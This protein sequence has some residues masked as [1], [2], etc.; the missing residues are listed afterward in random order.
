ME[1]EAEAAVAVAVAVALASLLGWGVEEEYNLWF[2]TASILTVDKLS[3]ALMPVVAALFASISSVLLLKTAL[4]DNIFPVA[5]ISCLYPSREKEVGDRY[6]SRGKEKLL[7]R[8]GKQHIPTNEIEIKTGWD[9]AVDLLFKVTT[10]NN[11]KRK[12]LNTRI[13]NMP[14]LTVVS[15]LEKLCCAAIFIR[16]VKDNSMLIALLSLSLQSMCYFVRHMV[17]T[18]VGARTMSDE[19]SISRRKAVIDMLLKSLAYIQVI[20]WIQL[21]SVLIYH[22]KIDFE[23]DVCRWS[24][25][26]VFTDVLGEFECG[27]GGKP[28]L[29]LLDL[30]ILLGQLQM[31]TEC[32]T[33]CPTKPRGASVLPSVRDTAVNIP[34]W[35]LHKYGILS[36][37][38]FDS[39]GTNDDELEL[40]AGNGHGSNGISDSILPG[41]YG[42]TV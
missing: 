37:L 39:L 15:Q 21:F 5:V 42:S 4:L 2:G 24:Y 34:N 36:I 16:Y 3:G 14:T 18:Y 13:E 30:I 41:R 28:I 8:R 35:K 9:Q 27:K 19:E 10:D 29:F 20:I 17:I 38:R 6:V 23:K 40:Y 22:S 33:K 7:E 1:A 12:E 26:Y 32:L 25:G 11:R 31:L